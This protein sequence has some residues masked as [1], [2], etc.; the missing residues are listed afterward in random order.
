MSALIYSY[1]FVPLSV[2]CALFSLYSCLS[3]TVSLSVLFR[4]MHAMCGGH[5]SV[6]SCVL[7]NVSS[8]SSQAKLFFSL[9]VMGLM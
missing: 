2:N 7:R 3:L 9:P 5:Q 4:C 8:R 6:R 1:F